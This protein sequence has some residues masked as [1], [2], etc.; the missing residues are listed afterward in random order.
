MRPAAVAALEAAR[1][2]H[3]ILTFTE[4][5]HAFFNDTN[6]ARFNAAAAA[7][8]YRRVLDWFDKYVAGRDHRD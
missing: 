8:A 6:A 1:L 7:E 4:A 3:L 2:R 5:N